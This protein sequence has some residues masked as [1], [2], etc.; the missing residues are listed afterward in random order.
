MEKV[1]AVAVSAAREWIICPTCGGYGEVPA[2]DDGNLVDDCP[3]CD[4]H[5]EIRNPDY[6]EPPKRPSTISAS[7]VLRGYVRRS[8]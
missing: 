3:T 1:E 7:E 2:K 6:R 4:G 5:L 8:R